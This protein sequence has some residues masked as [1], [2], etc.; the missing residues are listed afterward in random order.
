VCFK[1]DVA[2]DCFGVLLFSFVGK[3]CNLI[4]WMVG[5]CYS[6]DSIFP[7]LIFFHGVDLILRVVYVSLV[8]ANKCTGPLSRD[9][10]CQD[11]FV[12]FFKKKTWAGL[13]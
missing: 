11:K 5:W 1:F 10:Y 3:A 4:L 7:C 13:L 9:S 2:S 6:Y 12:Y 8:T